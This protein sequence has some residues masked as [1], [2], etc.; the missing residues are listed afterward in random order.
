MSFQERGGL[1]LR[2]RQAGGGRPLVPTRAALAR[3][4]PEPNDG[5]EGD[6]PARALTL[7]LTLTLTLAL[8]LTQAT[9][10]LERFGS[11]CSVELLDGGDPAALAVPVDG[12]ADRFVSTYCLDLMSEADMLATLD[13]AR[14]N[15][16]DDASRILTM[17]LV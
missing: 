5:R 11:R 12:G 10:R 7:T 4:R 6:R 8:T 17:A 13:K 15:T 2:A 1:R 9:A 3:R 14:A 16:L